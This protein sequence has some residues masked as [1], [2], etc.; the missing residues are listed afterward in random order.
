MTKDRKTAKHLYLDRIGIS[1][2]VNLSFF[3]ER[4]A[5]SIETSLRKYIRTI[6]RERRGIHLKPPGTP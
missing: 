6:T 4:V 1:I 5:G 2:L 3:L